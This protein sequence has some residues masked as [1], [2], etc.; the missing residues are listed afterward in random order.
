MADQSVID[1]FRRGHR[2]ALPRL[3]SVIERGGPSADRVVDAIYSQSGKADVIG[4]TGPPGAGKSTLV[5]GLIAEFRRLNR[6]V[7]VVAI[8]PS[9]P[10]SGGAA[11]GDRVRMMRHFADDDVFIRSMAA[12]GLLGG[13]APAVF[14][15]V[16]LLDAA[17]FDPI[18][19]ETVGV[20]QGELDIAA[21][22]HLVAV[23]QVPGLG[24]AVQAMKAGLLEIADLIL[25]NKA[26]LPGADATVRDFRRSFADGGRPDFPIARIVAT[27]G[28]G[29]PAAA[30]LIG[31]MLGALRASGQQEARQRRIASADVFARLRSLH[32]YR[33]RSG[34]T[35][36]NLFDRVVTDVAARYI[37]PVD[38]IRRLNGRI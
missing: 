38:A 4:V 32:E 13:L 15:A 33:F 5:D 2:R 8:D 24:D 11:L 25:V 28:E 1:A 3:L 29:L 19:I 34:V 6:R 7:A 17:R 9:S 36:E 37:S 14:G 22:A 16:Y 26:D 31:E 30:R 18:I 27:T 21:A 10:V 20:G 12:R 23:V 35:G